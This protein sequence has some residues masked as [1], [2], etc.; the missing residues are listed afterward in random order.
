[1]RKTFLLHQF[2]NAYRQAIRNSKY[3]WLV[4]LGTLL[5]LVSPI[6]ISPDVI[7]LIGW[8]DDGLIATLLLTE[9]SQIVTESLKSKKGSA[10]ASSARTT[11]EQEAEQIGQVIDVEAVSVG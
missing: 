11:P 7:P 4:V 1:M 9:V 2:Q 6:D 10:A 8:V 5:Y 3:R